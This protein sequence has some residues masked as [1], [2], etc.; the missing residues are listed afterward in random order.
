MVAALPDRLTTMLLFVWFE[1]VCGRI[2]VAMVRPSLEF[3]TTFERTLSSESPNPQKMD[4]DVYVSA[5]YTIAQI[6][7]CRLPKYE[8]DKNM[9]FCA[10]VVVIFHDRAVVTRSF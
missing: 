6:L 3:L 2:E 8:Q 10:I 7:S 9:L 5:P 1:Y 4:H